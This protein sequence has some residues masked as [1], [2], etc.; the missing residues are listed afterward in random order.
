MARSI[1]RQARTDGA[2]N[3]QSEPAAPCQRLSQSLR[4]LY[5]ATAR[6]SASVDQRDVQCMSEGVA[7]SSSCNGWSRLGALS[8]SEEA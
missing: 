5:A 4:V 8:L 6:N 2:R 1:G 3:L 7:I